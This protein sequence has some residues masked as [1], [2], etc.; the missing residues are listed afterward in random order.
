[1]SQKARARLALLA[2][3]ALFSTGGAAIKG[4]SFHGFELAGLRSAVAVLAFLVFL[5]RARA[6]PSPRALLVAL[7]YA[8]TLT[9]F[10]LANKLTSAANAIFLQSTAP[11]YVLLLAPLLL[12]ER[13][14][15][16][17]LLLLLVIA[18]GIVCLFFDEGAPQASASDPAL[19]NRLALVSGLTWALTMIGLRWLA[20]GGANPDALGAALWG[21]VFAAVLCLGG[22]GLRGELTLSEAGPQSWLLVGYL[23]VFQIG[24]AYALVTSAVQHVEAFEVSLLLLLEPVLNPLWAL[25]FEGERPGFYT[26]LGGALILGATLARTFYEARRARHPYPERGR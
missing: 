11:L 14:R 19:G 16:R 25:L 12:R 15:A 8:A 13:V 22:A 26:L 4:T 21:N 23:G 1:M 9:G 24:L 20:R 6:R 2:A 7:A 5:P 17:D 3:A 10:V 18:G